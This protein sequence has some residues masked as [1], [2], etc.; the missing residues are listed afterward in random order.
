MPERV[1][2]RRSCL[3]RAVAGVVCGLAGA[4]SARA[5][6]LV[7]N[8]PFSSPGSVFDVLQLDLYKPSDGDQPSKHTTIVLLYGGSYDS[9]RKEDLSA[10]GY[11]LAE[12]G[13]TVILPNYTLTTP[14]APSFPQAIRDTLNA[15][16]WART[17][18]AA[19][20]DVPIRLV[21]GGFSAGSTIA[22]TAALAAPQF[23][24][25]P[26]PAQRGYIIDGALGVS[27]RYDLVW[28]ISV[29][30]PATVVNYVGTPIY[31][32]GWVGA[33]SAASAITYVNGCSPPTVLFHGS[34]DPLIPANNAVRLGQALTTAT[35]PNEVNIV[36][37][38][39][40]DPAGVLGSAIWQRAERIDQA[41]GFMLQNAQAPCG[42]TP[43]PPPPPPS[44]S[45]CL[46][47]GSCDVL[48]QAECAGQWQRG[49][50]CNPNVCPQ[51]GVPGACCV[52]AT[53]VMLAPENCIGP[54]TRFTGSTVEC[55]ALAARPCCRADFNQD[56][57]VAVA[58]IFDFLNL[59]FV[60]SA[61]AAIST[62]GQSMPAIEDV[63]QFLNAWFVGCP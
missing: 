3:L 14:S 17:T 16:H 57:V 21:V 33:Y 53:C 41:V 18:G 2:T 5:V 34:H 29:G 32:S 60:G 15:V 24:T 42:R 9:G 62:N 44:G 50:T 25:F 22:M 45:C 13:Y 63:F 10:Y 26:A 30:I 52:G 56:A 37:S 48:V 20:H 47:T 12:M 35:V 11:A 61:D 28:N 23:A 54:R 7:Y 4:A 46:S 27:G 58:D 43:T 1:P 55:G 6:E 36:A 31:S 19:M 49:G 59:W 51:P 39:S 40:H 38:F 8:V